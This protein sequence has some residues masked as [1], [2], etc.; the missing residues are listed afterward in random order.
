MKTKLQFDGERVAIKA[1]EAIITLSNA[2][3][4]AGCA[5]DVATNIA[6]HLTD[7]S[8][9]GLESHGLMRVL[10]YV[11]QF[12]TGVMRADAR[13]TFH[14]LDSGFHEVNGNGGSG[15]PAMQL[16]VAKSCELARANGLCAIAI[17][18]TGHT[19]RLGA[20][21]EYAAERACMT[22][23]IGGG[24]RKNWRQVAPYGGRKAVLPTNPY[25]I[26]ISGGDRGPVIL[27]FA[28]SKIAGGWIYAAQS[29]GARIPEN[30]LIDP[31]GQPS[32]DPEDY[33]RGGAILPA[34]GAK[35][36]ALALIAEL[37]GEAMLGPATSETNWLMITLNTQGFRDATSMQAIAEEILADCRQCPPLPGFDR[38]EIPGE[39]ERAQ[40]KASNGIIE[41]PIETWKQIL[42]LENDAANDSSKSS[43]LN[44]TA[45]AG[46]SH[47]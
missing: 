14:T 34:G 1:D 33:F 4:S 40:R 37:I 2:L 7:A 20:F 16:A 43:H 45:S 38:V 28:T 12:N 44:L 36:Y 17:R 23:I 30:S 11:E 39:R 19:G 32:T 24:N 15:I 10:Q 31:D 13:A 5:P 46:K 35:G 22:I 25:C 9:C 26:G 18:H 27:D 47:V 8:L 3:I 6:Q 42:A 41:V 21:A 29:A